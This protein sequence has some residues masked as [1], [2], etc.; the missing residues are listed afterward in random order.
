MAE[1]ES[2][3]AAATALK[4]SGTEI[5]GV[6][7]LIATTPPH[8]GAEAHGA[9]PS[10][11]RADGGAAE[12]RTSPRAPPRAPQIA[13]SRARIQYA[14]F[15]TAAAMAAQLSV[16]PRAQRL[17]LPL[18]RAPA[19]LQGLP[20]VAGQ[21][22]AAHRTAYIGNIHPQLTSYQVAQFFSVCGPIKQV[23]L[24]RRP[25]AAAALATPHA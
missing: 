25:P 24:R 15:P 16:R 20:G 5:L 6:P 17:C 4:L 21:G 7:L 3:E 22:D 2:D 1:Y 19:S 18:S 11:S 8:P 13:V 14:S 23:R 10:G 12:V 9:P